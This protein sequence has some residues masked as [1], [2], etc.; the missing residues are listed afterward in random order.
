MEWSN[1]PPGKSI[2]HDSNVP[3]NDIP[4]FSWNIPLDVSSD[5]YTIA[6]S[7]TSGHT[8]TGVKI[9]KNILL[10]NSIEL[11]YRWQFEGINNE[12]FEDG[13]ENS[14]SRTVRDLI[15]CH[16][17]LGVQLLE[18]IINSKNTHPHVTAEALRWIGYI[19]D[20]FTKQARRI[21]LEKHIK[22]ESYIIRDGAILGL[23]YLL[24]PDS[25]NAIN[26][27]LKEES[28]KELREDLLKLK[29]QLLR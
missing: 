15:R 14:I 2:H 8:E 11:K 20:T 18:R 17:F 1:F 28:S 5:E 21:L 27:A 24:D 3:Y 12:Y 4:P 7:T 10:I 13:I 6:A 16:S 19:K 26:N 22:S 23:A 29:K 25:I 9:I